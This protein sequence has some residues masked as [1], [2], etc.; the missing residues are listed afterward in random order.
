VKF[1]PASPGMAPPK[2]EKFGV[3]LHGLYIDL[4]T[5]EAQKVVYSFLGNLKASPYV[6]F[7]E[8]QE[9][10]PAMG[11]TWDDEYELNVYLKTPIKL[12]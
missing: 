8:P 7:T 11:D 9:I 1:T 10:K 3:K 5:G 6:E 4:G 12:Q 2:N